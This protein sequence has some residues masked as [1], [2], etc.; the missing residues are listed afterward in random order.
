MLKAPGN[1]KQQIKLDTF[2]FKM[3][4]WSWQ[5]KVPGVSAAALVACDGSTDAYLVLEDT[6]DAAGHAREGSPL[7]VVLDRAMQ[8]LKPVTTSRPHIWARLPLHPATS[9]VNRQELLA[10]SSDRAA[11]ETQWH[12]KLQSLQ[13]RMLRGYAAWHALLAVL[14]LFR[15]CLDLTSSLTGSLTASD[16]LRQPWLSLVFCSLCLE[17]SRCVSL[18]MA[19]VRPAGSGHPSAVCMGS[20]LGQHGPFAGQS[21]EVS[22]GS[23]L[24]IETFD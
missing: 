15:A 23:C 20:D 14:M 5:A 2:S 6:R 9:K 10:Q 11:R 18:E 4:D 13:R 3:V 8:K 21:R 19:E 22:G 24:R 12:E 1:Y 17:S 16:L 7:N